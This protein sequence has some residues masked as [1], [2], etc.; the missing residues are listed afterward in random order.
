MRNDNKNWIGIILVAIGL[1]L[2][3]DNF[4][5]FDFDIRHLLFSWHTLFLIIGIIILNNSK[6][7]AV[8]IIFVVIGLFG[9]VGRI[10]PFDFHFSFRDYWPILL[11]IIGFFILFRKR[12]I[13]IPVVP[14][15]YEGSQMNNPQSTT[16]NTIDESTV[17]NSVNRIIESDNFRGGRVSSIFGSTKLNFTKSKLAPG[18]N[19]LEINCIFGGCDITLPKEWKVIVNVSAV[20]GGFDDKRYIID[21]TT[22]SDSVLII[23]GAVIF[24][25]GELISY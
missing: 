9:I 1:L 10:A 23:K 3:A 12:E 11:I 25:G 19:V 4:F 17:F 16:Y 20:F 14:K 7:S 6:N 13:T 22:G 15:E 21:T 24:G 8:G 18:E 5:F 2:I